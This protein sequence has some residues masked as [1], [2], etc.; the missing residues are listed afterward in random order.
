M[1]SAGVVLHGRYRLTSPVAAGGMGEVWRAEDLL[2]HREIAVKVLL[3]ALM[4]DRQFV[5]RF[6]AEARMMAALRHPGIAPI[7]DYGENAQVGAHRFDYLV[8][9]FIDGTPLS[10]R[11]QQAGRLGAAETMT[12]VAQVADALQ[13]AHE[14]GIVHRDVKP[15]NLLLRPGGD[16]VLVDFGVARSEGMTGFTGTDVVIGSAHFMAPEQ[17]EGRP[18]SAATDVYAL[19]AVAFSCLAGRPPYVGDSPLA[20]LA[21]LV[22]GQSPVL[23]PDVPAE[24]AAVVSRAMRKDPDQRYASASDLAAAARA[25]RAAPEPPPV[26]PPSAEA[27]E[28]VTAPRSSP[29]SPDVAPTKVAGPPSGGRRGKT[30]AAAVAVGVLLAGAG[31]WGGRLLNDSAGQNPGPLGDGS[32]PAS[33]TSGPAPAAS[34]PAAPASAAA[35]AYTPVEICSAG[36]NR[37][38]V[39]ASK[40]LKTSRGVLQGVVYLL[41]SDTDGSHCAVTMKEKGL[42]R[43]TEASVA[44]HV[45]GEL[46]LVNNDG[47]GSYAVMLSGRDGACVR[48]TGWIGDLSYV[49]ESPHCGD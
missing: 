30:V 9:E 43:S 3:P 41:Y 21:Q 24:V 13:A 11:I 47:G 10:T 8:M 49:S 12:V 5:A 7:H 20:V 35:R 36:G 33:D 44:V 17:A 23:P 22:H 2:L 28:M 39:V 48:W 6:R 32:L 46:G 16:V 45:E 38:R 19:G 29:P 15:N 34:S 4:A 42:G 18:V 27:A 1:L 37:Y 14:A 31:A 40:K 26:P 25:A